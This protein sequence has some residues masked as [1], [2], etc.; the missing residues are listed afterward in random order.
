[1]MIFPKDQLARQSM[2]KHFRN[3]KH[4]FMFCPIII[5]STLFRAHHVSLQ[6]EAG[7]T[8]PLQ[9]LMRN[10]LKPAHSKLTLIK[11]F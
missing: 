4:K 11:D 2:W 8:T 7:Y 10:G 6:V 3:Q 9:Y 1:M 5:F